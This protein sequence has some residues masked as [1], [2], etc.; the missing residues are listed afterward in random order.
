MMMRKARNG[1]WQKSVWPRFGFYPWECAS[2]RVEKLLRDRGLR[3][4][5]KRRVK[6][7]DRAF[8]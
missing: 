6:N 4:R 3:I 1:F 2:C 5:V 7:E 8:S